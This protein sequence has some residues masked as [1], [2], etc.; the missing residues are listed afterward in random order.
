MFVFS[1]NQMGQILVEM[2]PLV[3]VFRMAYVL[4]STAYGIL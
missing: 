1:A 3:F 2:L 4:L